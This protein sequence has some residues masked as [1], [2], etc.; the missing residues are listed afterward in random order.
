M[1]DT[2]ACAKDAVRD[3]TYTFQA[4]RVARQWRRTC[5]SSSA[6]SV[7][8]EEVEKLATDNLERP[9]REEDVLS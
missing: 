9:L 1:P 7:S 8:G 5:T 4:I 3:E 2:M 6:M